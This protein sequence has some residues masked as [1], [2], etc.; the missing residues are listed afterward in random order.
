MGSRWG[1]IVS[2]CGRGGILWVREEGASRALFRSVNSISG[3]GYKRLYAFLRW[4][5]GR[6][7]FLMCITV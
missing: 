6:R 7:A 1:S 3:L 2:E 5:R 4:G